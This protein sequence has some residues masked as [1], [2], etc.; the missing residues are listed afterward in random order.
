MSK[1]QH[2]RPLFLLFFLTIVSVLGA[3]LGFWI[4]FG[5]RC[6]AAFDARFVGNWLE[7][8]VAGSA[9]AMIS[10]MLRT[11]DLGL[12]PAARWKG[13]MIEAAARALIGA[14][15]GV[16][17]A[18]AY[19][20]GI[21]LKQ[22]IKDDSQIQHAVRLFLCIA[23]GA[24]ERIL[25]SLV[26]KAE[27]LLNKEGRDRSTDPA[28]GGK[29]P[30]TPSPLPPQPGPGTQGTPDSGQAAKPLTEAPAETVH[31]AESASN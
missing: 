15:T 27:D 31:R 2:T 22:I 18:L 5:G 3:I 7:A 1:D 30:G 20:S 11:T 10:A 21:L 13:L 8:A 26:G 16:L 4:C 17:I 29:P 23:S 14:G 19:E 6:C 9:G 12:E 25:P 24:S 28:S